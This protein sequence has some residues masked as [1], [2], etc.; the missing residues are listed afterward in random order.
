MFFFSLFAGSVCSVLQ[1]CYDLPDLL[2]A[3]MKAPSRHDRALRAVRFDVFA[4]LDSPVEKSRVDLPVMRIGEIRRRWFKESCPVGPPLTR[5]SMAGCTFVP[6][7]IMSGAQLCSLLNQ[8]FRHLSPGVV[9][10]L[11]VASAQQ[12]DGH[13]GER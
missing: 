6:E 11:L 4:S 8:P 7:Q 9:R 13:C 2:F 12:Q 5:L 10:T 1:V 3:E